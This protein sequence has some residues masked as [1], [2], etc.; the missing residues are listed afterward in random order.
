MRSKFSIGGHPLHPMLVAI[1]IGLFAWALVSD[2][3]Y[4]ATD[5]D[6]MWY[7]ISFWSSIAGIA[8]A[9]L[10]AA[11][12]FGDYMTIARKSDARD[13]ATAHMTLNLSVTALFGIATLL[14]LEDGALDGGRLGAVVALHAVAV[15]ML[16]I[17]GWL[18]GEMV[19][20]KHL[21]MIPD[22]GMAEAEEQR[23]RP[24][25]GHEPASRA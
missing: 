7:D 12:G 15:G 19:F 21:A 6:H 3:V 16:L 25:A 8:T 9:L 20:R 14:M 24:D 23:H 10:A 1:P 4:L 22:E 11:P 2:I 13:M 17:S 18:G 5:R